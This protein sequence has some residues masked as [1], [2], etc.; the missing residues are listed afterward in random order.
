MRAS[1]TIISRGP[2]GKTVVQKAYFEEPFILPR[3]LPP[4]P[5]N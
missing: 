5:K 2:G 1:M 3:P 4:T